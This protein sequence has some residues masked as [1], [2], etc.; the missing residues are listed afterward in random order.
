[1]EQSFKKEVEFL[2]LG[3]REVFLE[4]GILTVTKDLMQSGFSYEGG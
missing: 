4:V 1:M 3:E 2:R